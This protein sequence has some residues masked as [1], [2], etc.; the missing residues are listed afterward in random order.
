MLEDYNKPIYEISD[1]IGG[2]PHIS[3]VCAKLVKCGSQIGEPKNVSR[4]NRIDVDQC[5]NYS[6]SKASDRVNFVR[7]SLLV[8]RGWKLR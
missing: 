5:E 6:I 7:F 4:V 8:Q 3:W 2:P 1:W